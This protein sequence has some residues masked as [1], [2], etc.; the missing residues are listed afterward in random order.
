MNKKVSLVVSVYNE[1]EV[2][3]EFYKEVKKC[4]FNIDSDYE[5]IF[6]NDGSYDN[7]LN[8]IKSFIKDDKRV[9]LVS[10]SRNFG[11]EA[12]MIAGIDNASGEVI[13]CLD[14]DLQHPPEFIPN[15][16]QKFEEGFEVVNMVR[17][18]NKDAGILKNIGSSLFYVF[19]NALSDIKIVKNASDFFAISKKVADV[20][21]KDYREKIRFL[22]A[23][24]QIVGFK[25]TVIEYEAKK[26]VAG[27]S[28]YSLKSLFS[29]SF[30][31]IMR[32]SKLP[33]KVGFYAGFF[34]VC[35]GIIMS[36]Y[37]VY[38]HFFSYTPKGYTTIIVLLC[39]MFAMLF[40]IIGIIGQYIA[41]LFIELKDSP[42]YIIDEKVN[43]EE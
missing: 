14:S 29:L 28:K 22:R 13:I 16:L 36:I 19:I 26:R 20:L 6:V 34:S 31:T 24:I 7:S 35:L 2:L 11:H 42:I 4:L 21:R 43:I 10:F 37:T 27:Q 38:S 41:M 33:L 39:F 12:A 32:F 9:K 15:I 23:Y 8:I 3:N 30:N 1:D 18:E 17:T 25:K 40:F 5:I